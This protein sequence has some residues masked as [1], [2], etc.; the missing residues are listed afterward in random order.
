MQCIGQWLA[1]FLAYSP[2]L[3]S[4]QVSTLSLD[5]I[6]PAN[7]VKRLLRQLTFI[8]DMQVEKLASGMGN[9]ADFGDAVGRA[10]LVT[11]EVIAEQLAAPCAQT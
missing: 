11:G 1:F 7:R 9:A 10:C 2:A 8:S 6:Q 3:L 4:T 5:F